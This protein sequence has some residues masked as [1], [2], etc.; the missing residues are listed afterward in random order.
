MPWVVELSLV[1]IIW[2]I[3]TFKGIAVPFRWHKS[4]GI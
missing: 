1:L 3:E 4:S 2:L